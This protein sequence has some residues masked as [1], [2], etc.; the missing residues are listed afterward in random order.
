MD[1]HLQ[2][3]SAQPPPKLG[4][5]RR[6]EIDINHRQPTFRGRPGRFAGEDQDQ[7]DSAGRQRE[8]VSPDIIQPEPQ[9]FIFSELP[10]EE[11][12]KFMDFL[13]TNDV[14][15]QID[16]EDKTYV[17]TIKIVNKSDQNSPD[18][19]GQEVINGMD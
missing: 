7:F 1:Y 19:Y 8:E 18:E 11:K 17:A 10:P 12:V 5:P 16:P 14:E 6:S 2:S 9:T 4:D 13:L 15:F 3:Y